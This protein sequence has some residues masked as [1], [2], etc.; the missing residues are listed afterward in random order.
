M[1]NTLILSDIHGRKYWK[2]ILNNHPE[3]TKVVFLG[4]YFDSFD[5][6]F[7]DQIANFL[8]IIALKESG[9]Y[10]VVA[11]FGNHDGYLPQMNHNWSG[12]QSQYAN[13]IWMAM[14]P[15]IHHLQICHRDGDYIFSHAGISK[16]W[17][18]CLGLEERFNNS[19]NVDNILELVNNHL[20]Y[21]PKVFDFNYFGKRMSYDETGDDIWQGPTWIRPRAL[22]MSNYEHWLKSDFIQ[23]VG[24]T[25]VDKIDFEGVS[26][27]GRYYFIDTQHNVPF[28]YLTII[29]GELKLNVFYE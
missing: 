2:E 10:E 29:D 20:I 28:E 7:Q 22:K 27:G 16:D 26:T 25:G 23:I 8:D 1:K 6:L 9:D 13:I 17:L 21:K 5:I 19:N 12:Y 15:H 11:L 24:H 3:V 4:D 14:Q 18:K